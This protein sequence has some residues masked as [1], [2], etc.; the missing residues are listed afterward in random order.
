MTSKRIHHGSSKPRELH[1]V[2]ETRPKELPTRESRSVCVSAALIYR[3]GYAFKV[4][5]TAS[6]WRRINREG[7]FAFDLLRD[8]CD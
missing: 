2:G 1:C 8:G 3:R 4:A 6:A 7:V 5:D